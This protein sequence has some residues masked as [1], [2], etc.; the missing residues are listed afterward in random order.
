MGGYGSGRRTRF[1]SK[2]EDFHKLDL[3]SFKREWFELG[4]SGT[5]TWS[6]GGQKTGAISYRTTSDTLRLSY[7]VERDGSHEEIAETFG[8]AFTVQR[9]GGQRRWIVCPCGK[10]CRILYGGKY[11]RCRM[12]HR[13]T[14]ESQYERFRAPLICKAHK[15][16]ERLGMDAGFAYPFGDKPKGM[17]WKTYYRLREQ[18]WTASANLDRLIDPSLL[19]N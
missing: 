10:Q 5:V 19:R 8:F 2:V 15:V 11:F 7:T 16:R 18:D 12:C 9:F 17:H 4:K 13:L 3:A 14:Y 6:R 1:A